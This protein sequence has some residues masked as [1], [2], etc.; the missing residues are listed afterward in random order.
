M[1]NS[2]SLNFVYKKILKKISFSAL[3]YSCCICTM[4]QPNKTIAN[5]EST[6][7]LIIF[8]SLLCSLLESKTLPQRI[9]VDNHEK[10]SEDIEDCFSFF[11]FDTNGCNV[12]YQSI[13][14]IRNN[15]TKFIINEKNIRYLLRDIDGK[16]S[17]PDDYCMLDNCIYFTASKI[18]DE[19]FVLIP[20]TSLLA[21]G[22]FS[23]LSSGI[24]VHI[25]GDIIHVYSISGF[26]NIPNYFCWSYNE[27]KNRI[28]YLDI[29]IKDFS[30]SDRD[31]LTTYKIT[32]SYIDLKKQTFE[33]QR[34]AFG[35]SKEV[36]VTSLNFYQNS[37]VK[38]ISKNW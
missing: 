33:E 4:C 24:L 16:I 20:V 29:N 27:E 22:K 17:A 31:T 11:Q 23:Y 15:S 32:P 6:Q 18:S 3:V 38:L 8:D 13:C 14:G 28:D 9:F 21:Y 10:K 34:N 2:I 36:I 37:Q 7:D 19:K 30:S 12:K 26:E 1:K 5:V 25:R 35:V